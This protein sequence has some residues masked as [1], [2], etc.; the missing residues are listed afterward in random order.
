MALSI[1]DFRLRYCEFADPIDVPDAKIQMFIDDAIAIYVGTDELRWG[2]KY[3]IALSYI[4]AHL[5]T[6]ARGSAG[7]DTSANIG[8]ITSKS[9]GGVSLSTSGGAS[10]G[11]MS[12][13]ANFLLSTIYG[14]QFLTI[15]D[16]CFVGV[17]VASARVPVS[18]LGRF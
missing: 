18:S 4:T 12:R 11:V 10:S 16:V 15:R 6:I 13:S 9:A 5:M 8:A 1:V 14:Q 7:G 3:D 2:G 17:S